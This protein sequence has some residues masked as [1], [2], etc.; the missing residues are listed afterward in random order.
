MSSNKTADT[1]LA[2]C[3]L[4]EVIISPVK[5]D[6]TPAK[7]HSKQMFCSEKG[8]LPDTDL[9]P[10]TEEAKCS[11]S[12]KAVETEDDDSV[13]FTPELFDPVDT[14]D[15]ENSKLVETDRSSNNLDCFSAEELFE[16]V[17]GFGQK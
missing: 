12:S 10:G 9:S 7:N 3:P 4:S 14:D 17:T 1:S 2:P 15:E 5:V 8:L 16:T 13:C 6:A 11:G